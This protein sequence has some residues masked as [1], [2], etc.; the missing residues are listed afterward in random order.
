METNTDHRIQ[1][2]REF[3]ESRADPAPRG[4]VAPED[5]HQNVGAGADGRENVSKALPPVLLLL[6]TCDY[7]RKDSPVE[8]LTLSPEPLCGDKRRH[9]RGNDHAKGS[10]EKGN[11]RGKKGKNKR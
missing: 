2:H 3:G 9:E 8:A 10:R 4:L 6:H 5:P 7:Q 1:V 11:V